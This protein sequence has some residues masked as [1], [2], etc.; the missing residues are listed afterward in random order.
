MD[1]LRHS[2]ADLFSAVRILYTLILFVV[3]LILLVIAYSVGR[4]LVSTWG[5]GKIYLGEF[6]HYI[7][8]ELRPPITASKYAARPFCFIAISK[9]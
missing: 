4:E 8:T 6:I 7:L 2:V 5:R 9:E 3:I 1:V